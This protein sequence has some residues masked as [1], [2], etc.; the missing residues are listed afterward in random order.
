MDRSRPK[1]GRFL[2]FSAAPAFEK[3]FIFIFPVNANP[4]KLDHLVCLYLVDIFLLIIGKS[5]RPLL[6]IHWLKKVANSTPHLLIIDQFYDISYLRSLS[7]Y[8]KQ[9]NCFSLKKL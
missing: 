5:C 3:K 7:T 4:T 1:R 8:R 6:P 9:C 2:N